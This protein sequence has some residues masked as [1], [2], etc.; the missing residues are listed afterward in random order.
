MPSVEVSEAT[1]EKLRL[2]A[3]LTGSSPGAV[4]DVLV[5]RTSREG[6]VSNEISVAPPAAPRIPEPPI[7][8]ATWD[9]VP[10][11]HVFKGQRVEGDFRPSSFELRIRSAPWNGRVFASPTAAAQDVVG[12]WS[13]DRAT[14]N[15]NGRKFWR[16][17]T[18]NKDL[19][20]LV[21]TRF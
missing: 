10:V 12:R 5:D 18:S 19:R 4:V 17:N 14:N 9:W 21:G 8:E 6:H 15:T 20:S 2:T 11:H 1:L 7:P 16:V 13:P 3:N